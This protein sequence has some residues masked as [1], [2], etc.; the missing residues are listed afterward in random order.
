M[1]WCE[2]WLCCYL[3]NTTPAAHVVIDVFVVDDGGDSHMAYESK[4]VLPPGAI[5][6]GQA[7]SHLIV[8]CTDERFDEIFLLRHITRGKIYVEL[9]HVR[10][11]GF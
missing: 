8:L 10:E 3:C 7:G 11:S 9:N 6:V 5:C 2:Q 4:G 1:L